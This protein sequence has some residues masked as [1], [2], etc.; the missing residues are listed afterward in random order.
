MS[1]LYFFG[2]IDF[3][4]FMF[5]KIIT[6]TSGFNINKMVVFFSSGFYISSFS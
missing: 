4:I 3:N 5:I 2:H 1:F 6:T